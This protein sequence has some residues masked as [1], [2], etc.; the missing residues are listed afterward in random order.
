MVLTHTFINANYLIRISNRNT[1]NKTNL[2]S[3]RHLFE[4]IGSITFLKLSER[5]EKSTGDKF[6]AKLRRGL[7][8]EFVAR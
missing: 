1:P 7:K 8:I 5:L 4:L 2:V 6:T 3:S